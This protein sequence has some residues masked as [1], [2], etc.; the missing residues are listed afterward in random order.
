MVVADQGFTRPPGPSL[1]AAARAT[2]RCADH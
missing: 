2:R 1:R